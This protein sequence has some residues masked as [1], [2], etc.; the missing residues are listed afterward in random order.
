MEPA[1]GAKLVGVLGQLTSLDVF[2]DVGWRLQT[3]VRDRSVA[4]TGP[5]SRRNPDSRRRTARLEL[6]VRGLHQLGALVDQEV[7][8]PVLGE[9]DAFELALAAEVRGLNLAGLQL[10]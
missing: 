7:A 6:V 8:G 9:L 2:E 4:R 10:A 5:H 1:V 3:E